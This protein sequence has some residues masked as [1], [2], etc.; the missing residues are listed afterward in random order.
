MPC[1]GMRGGKEDYWVEHC[2]EEALGLAAYVDLLD[3]CFHE[4]HKYY[5]VPHRLRWDD[6]LESLHNIDSNDRGTYRQNDGLATNS[7]DTYGSGMSGGTRGNDGLA[8]SNTSDN[9]SSGGMGGMRS[10]DGLDPSSTT[11][12]YGGMGSTRRDDEG[13]SRRTDEGLSTAGRYDRSAGGNY[14]DPSYGERTSGGLGYDDTIGTNERTGGVSRGG[15]EETSRYTSGGL[16]ENDAYGD[17]GHAGG[18]QVGA[19]QNYGMG[20]GRTVDQERGGVLPVE[21]GRD[22]ARSSGRG[23]EYGVGSGRD[24][25]ESSG[26]KK[27]DST[28][29][30]LMEKAGG[31]LKNEK[32]ERQGEEKRREAG[33]Y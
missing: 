14:D 17:E 11:D 23:D 18:N 19:A 5:D 31:M 8:T 20:S 21:P 3:C 12:A 7:D 2:T 28:M 29:G 27:K 1:F 32:I 26:G 10:N 25:D 16:G 33:G 30:K 24:D 13:L 6:G 9:Y 22:D 15:D 4:K